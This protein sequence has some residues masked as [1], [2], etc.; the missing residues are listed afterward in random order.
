MKNFLHNDPIDAL[1]EVYEK[2]YENTAEFFH[3]TEKNTELLPHKSIDETNNKTNELEKLPQKDAEDDLARDLSDTTRYLSKS[4][5]E[6]KDWLAFETTLVERELLDYL[7]M[8]AD[9]TTVKLLQFK[10]GAQQASSYPK[11]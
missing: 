2:M 11:Y 8:V 1:G 3:G 10:E 7:L 4:G 6:L 9:K 5:H